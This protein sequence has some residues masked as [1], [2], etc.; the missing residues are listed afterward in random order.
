MSIVDDLVLTELLHL[1]HNPLTGQK[2]PGQVHTQRLQPYV[3]RMVLNRGHV[4]DPSVGEKNVHLAKRLNGVGV[5]D[6]GEAF[7][8]EASDTVSFL[9]RLNGG[10]VGT[11]NVSN[12]TD[13]PIG[14]TLRILGE[15]G[16]LVA[17]APGYYQ[18]TPLTLQAGKRGGHASACRG[19]SRT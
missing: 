10:A 15:D 6:T 17:R 13:P 18:F 12:I 9:A 8:W 14:F 2:L 7:K 11:V 5:A 4:E 1:G 16:Q 3:R 19:A